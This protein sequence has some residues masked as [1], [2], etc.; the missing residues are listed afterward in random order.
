MA[1]KLT[2]CFNTADFRAAAKKKLPG[3]IFDYLDGGSDNEISLKNNRSAFSNYQLVPR[4]LRDVSDIDMSTSIMGQNISFPVIFSPTGMNGLFHP[5]ADI[6]PA[7]AAQ[8]L[9]T[10]YTLSTFSTV[11][12]ESIAKVNTGAKM[13]QI[14][15][16]TDHDLNDDIIDRC[17]AQNYHAL[18]LTVDT[19]VPGNRER[20]LYHGMTM[21]PK[22][23]LKSIYEFATHPSWVLGFIKGHKFQMGNLVK[24]QSMKKNS[25]QDLKAYVSNLLETKLTW[26]HAQHMIERW[27]G[28]FAI[29][30]I[31]SVADAKQ[32]VKIGASAII[33]SNHGGRQLDNTPAPIELVKDIRAAVGP[34]IEIILDG[35]IRRGTD[36]LQ[37]I[38]L[39]ANACSVGRN[40]LYGLA[41]AGQEG[42]EHSLGLLRDEIERA[43]ILSG[44]KNI[45]EINQ[46][47]LRKTHR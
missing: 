3:P 38:A 9:D 45:A 11:D 46:E 34:D 16:T 12:L 31:L 36:V 27:G 40:Y 28:P 13:F 18:C 43:M 29:K 19:V 6:A 22:L 26:S 39:G 42:V 5:E 44:C 37:A 14:Y 41:A 33:I 24:A 7:K 17:K 10:L 15:V 35:G 23:T 2:R 8:N 20:D 4:V 1:V 30:G 47:I 21:P 32:A 25:K